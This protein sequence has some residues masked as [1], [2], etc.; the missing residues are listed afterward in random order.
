MSILNPLSWFR[1]A[2]PKQAPRDQV[3]YG[4][5]RRYGINTPPG[6]SRGILSWLRDLTGFGWP[7]NKYAGG[8]PAAEYVYGEKARGGP[9]GVNIPAFQPYIDNY[10]CETP[11]MRRVYREMLKDPYVKASLLDKDLDVASQ[12]IHV[13]P[14]DDH[15]LP[16]ARAKRNKEVAA[17]CHWALSERLHGGIPGLV[18]TICLHGLVNGYS[19]SEKV[20]Q[21]EEQHSKYTNKIVIDKLKAKDVDNDVVLDVDEYRNIVGLMG[22][23]YNAG[24][25]FSP[26]DFVIFEYLKMYE[27]P[28][29]MSDLTGRLFSYYWQRDVVIKL[30]LYGVE[31]RAIPPIWGSYKDQSRLR[32]LQDTLSKI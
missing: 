20:W 19:I 17:F 13:N 29:G 31:N 23:R 7:G 16:P 32:M 25:V 14:P 9:S 26:A 6:Q 10:T 24:A 2:K 3:G 4:I 8:T 27:I 21:P 18:N 5:A 30:R 12:D 28:G 11:E 1:P 15:G 22:L